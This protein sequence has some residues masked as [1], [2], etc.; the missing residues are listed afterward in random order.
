MIA[1]ASGR[2]R[3]Q[4]TARG[5]RRQVRRPAAGRPALRLPEAAP[6]GNASLAPVSAAR[7]PSSCAPAGR[8]RGPAPSC[9]R[10]AGRPRGAAPSCTRPAGRP[11]GP[12]P[13]CTRPARPR[14]LTPPRPFRRPSGSTNDA[15]G[16]R[17]GGGALRRWPDSG[18]VRR[19]PR[20]SGKHSPAGR[21]CRA[22]GQSRAAASGSRRDRGAVLDMSHAPD[23]L[24]PR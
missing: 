15:S 5:R 1:L 3:F 6:T 7:R 16:W 22:L 20:N 9:T 8:P 10:P 14:L 12:A 18:G 2:P 24:S 21:S 4:R 13:S 19:V 11:R 23:H 17:E